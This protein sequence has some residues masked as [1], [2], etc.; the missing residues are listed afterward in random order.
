MDDVGGRG[1][2][3]RA[4]ANLSMKPISKRHIVCD[5]SEIPQVIT[6][7][8]FEHA[9]FQTTLPNQGT[10]LFFNPHYL[11]QSSVFSLMRGL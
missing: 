4:R 5:A 7:G 10:H 6:N 2:V 3:L 9:N 8:T 11:S 1:Q